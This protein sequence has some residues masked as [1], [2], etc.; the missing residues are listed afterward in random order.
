M[1]THKSSMIMGAAAEK[2]VDWTKVPD[3]ELATNIDNTDSVGD[4]KSQ[5]KHRRLH[6][7]CDTEIWRVEEAHQEAEEQEWKHQ[8]EEVE[9]CWKEEEERHQK[10]AEEQ[11]QEAKKVC[12]AGVFVP[13][14]NRGQEMFSMQVMH[15]GQGMLEHKKWAKKAADNNNNDKIIMLSGQKTKWQGGSHI[16]PHGCGQRPPREDSQ[17]QVLLSK[18]VKIASTAGSG[19]SKEVV[20]D[21]EELKELQEMQGEESGGQ[22]EEIQVVPG[23]ALGDEPE[24]VLGNEPENGTGEEDGTGE[25][26]QQSKAKGK[27]KENPWE[28]T[29]GKGKQ[30]AI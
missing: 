7:A 27:G 28:E 25:E 11:K 30:R 24:D 2:I 3:E 26:G 5:E 20:K 1:S 23:G 15:E 21:P 29:Q 6:M 19:G 10:E 9:K 14:T 17:Q 13:H 18:L 8:A 4:A 22:E 12:K 16:Q